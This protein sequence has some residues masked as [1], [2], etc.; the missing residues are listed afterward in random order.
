M[1][2]MLAMREQENEKKEKQKT[3]F[4]HVSKYNRLLHVFELTT[5]DFVL[6]KSYIIR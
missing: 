5:N 4:K 1:C 2:F 6:V 3:P